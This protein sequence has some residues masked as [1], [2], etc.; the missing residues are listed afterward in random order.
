MFKSNMWIVSSLKLRVKSFETSLDL[1]KRR[2]KL[3]CT[4]IPMSMASSWKEMLIC[5]PVGQKNTHQQLWHVPDMLEEWKMRKQHSA[6]G[7]TQYSSYY[8]N[9]G[10]FLEVPQPTLVS[11]FSNINKCANGCQCKTTV[12]EDNHMKASFDNC[13]NP[14]HALLA[15]TQ[16]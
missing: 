3:D 8:N 11:N 4:I 15:P 1:K 13:S 16:F 9:T 14:T 10:F 12:R 7:H 5:F 6:T 2:T